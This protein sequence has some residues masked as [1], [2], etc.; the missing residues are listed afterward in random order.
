M[1]C[2]YT[3]S[4]SRYNAYNAWIFNGTLGYANNNNMNN[5]NR[6]LPLVNHFE[7]ISE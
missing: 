2:A 5:S 3:W 1:K 4:P 7:T 6:V